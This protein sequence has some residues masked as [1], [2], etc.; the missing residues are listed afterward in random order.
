MT[1]SDSFRA[2]LGMLCLAFF[3][4]ISIIV[5][6]ADALMDSDSSEPAAFAILM[7]LF[8]LVAFGLAAVYRAVQYGFVLGAAGRESKLPVAEAREHIPAS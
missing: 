4:L 5:G 2:M 8:A 3:G 1:G 7:G 6:F